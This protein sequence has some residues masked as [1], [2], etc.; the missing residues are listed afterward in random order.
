MIYFTAKGKAYR[1]NLSV[2]ANHI[3]G[4]MLFGLGIAGVVVYTLLQI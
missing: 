4:P 3:I 2:L 1:W